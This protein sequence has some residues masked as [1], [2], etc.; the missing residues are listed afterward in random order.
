LER[1]A[2]IPPKDEEERPEG[3]E[4]IAKTHAWLATIVESSSDAI[5]CLSGRGTILVWN[6]AAEALFGYSA[7]EA[8]G[9]HI[10]FLSGPEAL[11]D[12]RQPF[13][14][15]RAGESISGVEAAWRRK[16]GTRIEV[17]LDVYPVHAENGELVTMTA[18]VRNL[19]ASR[20]AERALRHSEQ[21]L[22][23]ALRAG[24]LAIWEWEIQT[25]RAYW[26]PEVYE[27]TGVAPGDFD[28]TNDDFFRRVHP[29]D[30]DGMWAL[31]ENTIGSDC[32]FDA[33]FRFR[34]DDG[35]VRWLHNMAQL[36][37]DEAGAASHLVG[38][39][40]DVT[41]RR[42]TNE[43]L[44][45]SEERFR[46]A[47]MV[48]PFPV[49]IQADDG[50]MLTINDAWIEISGYR[51]EELATLEAWTE[52]AHGEAASA[53]REL[54][55]RLFTEGSGARGKEQRV[56]TADG[57]KRIWE[58]STAPLGRTVDG[59]R[60]LITAAT[61]VTDHKEAERALRES[62]ERLQAALSASSTGTFRWEF[63]DGTVDWD[64]N[65][66]R[67][68]GLPVGQTVR[69]LD[70]FLEMVHP[71]DR[72]RVIQ[73]CD[74]C[75]RE[76]ADFA[77]EFRIVWPDG[78]VRWLDAHGRSFCDEA[79][80]PL[81][82]TGASVDVTP[83]KTNAIALQHAKDEAE[84]ASRAKD[85]FLATLSHE[86]RTPL[87]AILGWSRMI[88]MPGLRA[89]LIEE[90]MKSIERNARAQAQLVEDLLDI[91]RIISGKLEVK[92]GPMDL[93]ALIEAA[94]AT[95]RPTAEAKK[96]A[97]SLDLAPNAG[98]LDGDA[99][100]LQ[101]V[102]GNLLSNAVKFTPKG[103][104]VHVALS[105][106]GD[107][108]V[109]RVSDTGE[110]IAPD[111]LP[112][113]FDRF[114][115]ADASTTR[116][117]GGLGLGLAIVRHVVELHGGEVRA[118]SRGVGQGATLTVRLPR[119][120]AVDPVNR[121]HDASQPAAAEVTPG[122]LNGLH[123]LV[124]DDEHDGRALVKSVLERAGARVTAVESVALAL[125]LLDHAGAGAPDVLVSDIAMPGED[126]YTLIR[127][128]R[129][130]EGSDGARL[131][132]VALTARARVEDR[133]QALSSGFQ[134]HV[135]KPVE[136][137]ELIAVV[138]SLVARRIP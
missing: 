88:N 58:F 117:H 106:E 39:V 63:I 114:R 21:R 1:A 101:Q 123:V 138:A 66:D 98:S 112:L 54:I 119:H 68:C 83:Q 9:R 18:I 3:R 34:R 12:T 126:G 103:G 104:A 110:G 8:L 132:A 86:L 128:L 75:A 40:Q 127:R 20:R 51:R 125:P 5:M 62:R 79:G 69:T 121:E 28:E 48:A 41:E 10:A 109:M 70:V 124:V 45:E 130:T 99:D 105:S 19:G 92:L 13:E 113:V 129:E 50:E 53:V 90:G 31:V 81:Y 23:L 24:G 56:R 32:A 59:R 67:L 52:R 78:S 25:G 120:A 4:Q 43:A 42:R 115:Q 137:R 17:A 36:L 64:E 111:F 80:R 26:S 91:S 14:R 136:P 30:R 16:D 72:A 118:D 61:D 96:V 87:T 22:A 122:A 49:A 2:V 108:A 60:L 116:R 74:H 133:I 73:H 97:L 6:R 33:E 77:M 107:D 85:D 47:V 134:S 44:R 7:E 11:P 57:R 100:R 37:R 84:R 27:V 71:D 55:A 35:E 93:A 15:V 82:M 131:P 135:A 95:V 65:L 29:E 94:A 46:R 89:G 38:T 102:V 76:G